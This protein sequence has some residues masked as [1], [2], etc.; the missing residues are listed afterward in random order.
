VKRIAIIFIFLI[1]CID[2]YNP[3]IIEQDSSALV[4]DGFINVTGESTIRLTRSQNIS[5]NTTPLVESGATLW[6]EDESGVK[7]YMSETEPG[8]YMLPQQILQAS[9]YRLTIKTQNSKEYQSDFEPVKVGPPIDSVTWSIT[10]DLGVQVSVNTH[11]YGT[12]EG[13]Y[14][15]TYEETNAYVSAFNSAF[16]FNKNTHKVEPRRDDNIY[17][18]WRTTNS[19]DILL[20][21]TKRFSKNIIDHFP[22]R[23]IN[24]KSELTR[25]KYSILV[26]QYSI[27]EKAYNYWKQLRK[28][29]Y[30]LGTLFGPTPTQLT[31]NFRSLTNPSEIVVGYFYISS[32]STNR[33]FI[34][35]KNLPVPS[36]YETPYSGCETSV[37]ELADVPN[38][39]GPFLLI[40]EVFDG[41]GPNILGYYYSNTT[42]V[43]CRLTG[44]TLT[45]PDFW[46]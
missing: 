27:T 14:R 2:P 5:E 24:Q 31:G 18:C 43:D 15:W 41:F 13:F 6:I 3:P 1:S 37:L 25:F 20:E 4:I 36:F 38:F 34:S 9:K 29:S 12:E 7:I 45:K 28:N 22:L 30:D 39:S 19:T 35:S 46:E 16:I 26:T 10:D 40:S 44:G 42:C 21:S 8:K 17:S 33:I 11:D 23:Y 32:V